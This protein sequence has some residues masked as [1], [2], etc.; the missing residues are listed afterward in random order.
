MDCQ[1]V[2]ERMFRVRDNEI[3]PELLATFREHLSFCRDCDHLYAYIEKML[4][5]VRC[6]CTR[7]SAPATLKVR[8]LASLPH[9][10]VAVQEIVE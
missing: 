5:I 4:S 3:E 7:Y 6:R 2:R 8:I 10:S 9:R 1:G